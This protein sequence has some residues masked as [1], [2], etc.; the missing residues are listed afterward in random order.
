MTTWI[1]TGAIIATLLFLLWLY[2]AGRKSGENKAEVDHLAESA[3]MGKSIREMETD[4]NRSFQERVNAR[5][6]GPR[7]RYLTPFWLR[8]RDN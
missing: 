7:R 2:R 6:I 3:E 8:H 1:V 5:G 4:E